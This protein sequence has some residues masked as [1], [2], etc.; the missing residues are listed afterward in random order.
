MRS[1]WLIIMISLV[2]VGCNDPETVKKLEQEIEK[3][4]QNISE[5]TKEIS[6]YGE[7]SALYGL[8]N[9]RL[10]VYKQTLSMLEQKK[11]AAWYF[12]SFSYSVE[13]KLYSPPEDLASKLSTLE[14]ELLAAKKEAEVAQAKAASSG[15]LIG[16]LVSMEAETKELI[17]S[18]LNYQLIALRNGFPPYIGSTS[19]QD[20]K[21][22][23][24]SPTPV[25]L[26]SKTQVNEKIDDSQS[27]SAVDFRK[28]T[29]GMSKSQVKATEAGV[30]NSEDES[31]LMYSSRISGMNA[32]VI[33]IFAENKLVRAKY[34]FT[35]EHSN[36]NDY[37]TDYNSL[38]EALGKK[39]GKIKNEET[40]WRNDLYRDDFS[41]W[42]FAVSLGHLIYYSQWNTENT[43]ISLVLSGENYDIKLAAEYTSKALEK[44]EEKVREK[45]QSSEL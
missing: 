40:V 2:L 8:V 23:P 30:P 39:Y 12:P 31:V 28:T 6:K 41:Q 13:G 14:S 20:S 27:S 3:V 33:Y 26:E 29:W 35:E 21:L 5:T 9:L 44:L 16:A 37:I 36:R 24:P 22:Q 25:S 34:L 42:G 32:L 15:G 38:K 17:V 11:A 19:A 4:N 1:S 45:K 43:N 18:Q 7:G 10:S